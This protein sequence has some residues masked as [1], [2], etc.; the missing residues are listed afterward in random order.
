MRT[1]E[2]KL[3][4]KELEEMAFDLVI[5]FSKLKNPVEA[6][7]FT[8]DLLTSAEVRNLAKR[9]RIAKLLLE[10]KTYSEIKS[11]LR[12]S[13]ATVSKVSAWLH[14]SG[15]G[16]RRILTNLPRREEI[17]W[18]S[19]P[20]GDEFKL[21]YNAYYPLAEIN[22]KKRRVE[23]RREMEK[24]LRTIL[25]KLDKKSKLFRQIQKIY[26]AQQRLS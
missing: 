19:L 11:G 25:S 20:P 24:E 15:E 6:A 1:R 8:Q 12:V 2:E 3:G 16:F 22:L 21:K 14:E 13:S 23:K 17:D 18:G 7:S 5:A 4:K 10:G 26:E 9:L